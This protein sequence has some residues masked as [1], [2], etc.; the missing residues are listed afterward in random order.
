[1]SDMRKKAIAGLK[2]GEAFTASRT[3]TEPEAATFA[4]ISRD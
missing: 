4:A 2:I 3:F 1:M